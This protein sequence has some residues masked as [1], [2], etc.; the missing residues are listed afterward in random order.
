VRRLPKIVVIVGPTGSGKTELGI[1]LAKKWSGEVVSADSRQIY[2]ELSIGT[3]KPSGKWRIESGK[4][5]YISG[6]EVHHL[7]DEIDPKEEFT[8]ADFKERALSAIADVLSRGKLPI[9]VGGTG[10]YIETL[11]KNLDIPKVPPNYLLRT[12]L[13]K[14]STDELHDELLKKDP[15]AAVLTGKNKRRIIRALEVI[16]ATGEKFSQMRKRGPQLF[17]ALK[18]GLAGSKDESAIKSRVKSMIDEGLPDEIKL[19]TKKYSW[20]LPAM[21]SIDYQEFRGHLEGKESLEGAV[22]K[23]IAAHKELMRRQMVWFKKDRD[24]RWIKK[25]ARP[26]ERLQSFGR[27]AESLV[28][29]FLNTP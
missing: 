28:S 2:K 15:E 9:L 17:N 23:V 25:E 11:L 1:F 24:I 12:K 8:L 7:V 29:E 18:I 22:Q 5:R 21:Q 20:E 6:G 13:E 4:S 10:L 19:L 26:T 3:A 16:E 14:K 27:E